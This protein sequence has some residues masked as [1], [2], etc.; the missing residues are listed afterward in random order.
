MSLKVEPPWFVSVI[1]TSGGKATVGLG[2]AV[3][4]WL[5]TSVGTFVAV[6]LGTAVAVTVGATWM[7]L[8]AWLLV[9]LVSPGVVTD[10]AIVK[11]L[12]AVDVTLPVIATVGNWLP[13]VTGYGPVYVSCSSVGLVVEFKLT[14]QPGVSEMALMFVKPAGMTTMTEIGLPAT[15]ELFTSVTF[16][17]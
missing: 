14:V 11:L 4:V 5:G 10:A 7:V 6:G 2:C 9:G 3:A 8:T 16:R 15:T 13:C 12:P 17:L 1:A